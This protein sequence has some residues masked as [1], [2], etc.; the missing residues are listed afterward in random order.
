M[1]TDILAVIVNGCGGVGKDTL[2][3]AYV[4]GGS[5]KAEKYSSI[6]DVK[7]LAKMCGWN[8]DKEDRDRKFLSDLKCLLSE[9]ND[10]PFKS[11]MRSFRFSRMR[12]FHVWFCMVREPD[13]ID[14]LKW[15][16]RSVEE[17]PV[18]TLLVRRNGF[19]DRK[20]GNMADDNVEDYFYDYIF[21]NNGTIDTSQYLFKKLID[22]IYKEKVQSD[23]SENDI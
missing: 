20:Y 15:H 21:D 6:N 7:K 2:V 17:C 5:L 12:T 23:R 16:I 13:E 3:D 9:Y 22:R 4:R 8:G 19:E 10:L 18:V 14:K 11:C 1:R